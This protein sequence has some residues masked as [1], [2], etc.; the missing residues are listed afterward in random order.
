M[1]HK[2]RYKQLRQKRWRKKI[3]KIEEIK[4]NDHAIIDEIV[5]SVYNWMHYD[6]SDDRSG[7]HAPYTPEL[8]SIWT[9]SKY[10]NTTD[11]KGKT[12]L[13]H[14]AE[15]G[16]HSFVKTLLDYGADNSIQDN[17]GNTPLHYA[18]YN[19]NTSAH[20]DDLDNPYPNEY[21]C[22]RDKKYKY[23]E[24]NVT[25]YKYQYGYWEF[26]KV[27][28]ELLTYFCDPFIKNIHGETP[29]ELSG[30]HY[31]WIHTNLYPT[32]IVLVPIRTPVL[33]KLISEKQADVYRFLAVLTGFLS[34]GVLEWGLVEEIFEYLYKG[35]DITYDDIILS[36]NYCRPFRNSTYWNMHPNIKMDEIVR[37][38]ASLIKN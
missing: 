23:C 28:H 7:R 37:Y 21:H 13:H 15:H 29:L 26:D 4:N 27:V 18:V 20:Y 6:T 38:A 32:D 19:F 2:N 12:L 24:E 22:D 3:L 30:Y 14:L 10:I 36:C 8:N 17:E 11:K 31:G 16:C 9:G 25:D 1:P 34:L 5:H 33:H 35:S